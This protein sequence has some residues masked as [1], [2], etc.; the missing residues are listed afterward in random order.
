MFSS[1]KKNSSGGKQNSSKDNQQ[2]QNSNGA[3]VRIKKN[4][5]PEVEFRQVKEELK[6]SIEDSR[7][8]NNTTFIL[9]SIRI[10]ERKEMYSYIFD[11]DQDKYSV[12][13]SGG[14][15]V[16]AHQKSLVNEE[17]YSALH[18]YDS[19]CNLIRSFPLTYQHRLESLYFSPEE[20]IVVVYTD[21]HIETYTIQ[22]RKV[23][24]LS[25]YEGQKISL[26]FVSFW[27]RGLMLA[28][29]PNVVYIID[30]FV[31]LEP[32]VFCRFSGD[33]L[34]SGIILPEDPDTGVGIRLWCVNSKNNLV[35]IQ[36]DDYEIQEFVS[37]VSKILFSPNGK[38]ALAVCK[39]ITKEK[40]EFKDVLYYFCTPDFSEVKLA[41]RF[42]AFQPSKIAWCGSDAIC[43][44]Q[45]FQLVLIG[46]C[47]DSIKWELDSP[48]IISSEID[49]LR[50][51]SMKGSSLLRAITRNVLQFCL[52]NTKSPQVRLFYVM[53]DEVGLAESDLV[54][55]DDSDKSITEPTEGRTF[56][57]KELHTALQGILEAALFFKNPLVRRN[58]LKIG[59]RVMTTVRAP[60]N[61]TS[62]ISQNLERMRDFF[63]FADKLSTMRIVDQLNGPPYNI[64][65]TF[66]QFQ[67]LNHIVLLKRLCNRSL[68]YEASQLA[69][70]VG[71]DDSYINSHWATSLIFTS[72]SDDNILKSYHSMNMSIDYVEVA[73]TAFDINRVSLGLKLLE[74]NKA[75]ARAVPL[76]VSQGQ[77]RD[78]LTAAINSADSSL[79]VY[80]LEQA[81]NNGQ[82]LLLS[83][84]LQNKDNRDIRNIYLRLLPDDETAISEVL[85]I[86][87]RNAL[88]KVKKTLSGGG[89]MKDERAQQINKLF[90][91]DNIIPVFTSF[92]SK[93]NTAKEYVSS[94][95]YVE[96]IDS[97]TPSEVY[98]QVILS[99]N[100]N[101]TVDYGKDIFHLSNDEIFWRRLQTGLKYDSVCLIK[102][103]KKAMSKQ[104]GGAVP[105]WFM[106]Y[107]SQHSS[108]RLLDILEGR[109]VEDDP[110]D[111]VITGSLEY[112]QQKKSESEKY[113]QKKDKD[114]SNKD[115]DKNK[116]NKDKDNEKG[117]EAQQDEHKDN[118][119]QQ[120]EEVT[121]N[122]TETKNEENKTVE[123]E[124]PTEEKE[125]EETEL[126]PEKAEQNPEA[127]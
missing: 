42:D 71:V 95:R 73:K 38:I 8:I 68:Y 78:A 124:K 110:N 34:L 111:P 104:S 14:A 47:Q 27:P 3:V 61:D 17:Y 10:F 99:N 86:D 57:V 37:P 39:D 121:E 105:E 25:E 119:E 24:E 74:C 66:A 67:S 70:Y 84:F 19:Y 7:L 113:N 100:R 30:N 80:T 51:F 4:L 93:L 116:D 32:R 31:H 96:N 115:K 103:F 85:H 69:S 56:T 109:E 72:R 117:E 48:M 108:P 55:V 97:L 26:Q 13:P 15:I 126:S 2:E 53:N 114:K 22:G 118:A 77:W 11:F 101:K 46:A 36:E 92:Y 1:S 76:L 54:I 123:E 43:M 83:E 9:E 63:G 79:L 81:M 35:L 16:V 87:N 125:K 64:P 28:A 33:S 52:Q 112:H 75:K 107:A 44:T 5:P 29:Y 120:Q 12:A 58:F 91:S 122:Q 45:G 89:L 49:G 62:V 6:K 65:V 82:Y 106:S 20:C 41:I 88:Y 23:C 98:E 50:I 59:T 18:I 127:Q 102:Q 40:Y 90:S 21:A 94:T 60:L